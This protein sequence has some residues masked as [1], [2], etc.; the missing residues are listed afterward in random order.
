MTFALPMIDKCRL[1][2]LLR[3]ALILLKR[4][5]T[6]IFQMVLTSAAIETPKQVAASFLLGS[7]H[8]IEL[9]RM[10][11]VLSAFNPYPGKIFYSTNCY[12][13]SGVT[14]AMSSAYASTL[15]Q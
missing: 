15:V 9:E 12:L 5:S 3:S 6:I 11:L 13:G 2:I 7:C 10:I 14:T 1:F 4:G 8:R